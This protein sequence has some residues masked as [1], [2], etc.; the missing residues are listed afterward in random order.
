MM[1]YIPIAILSVSIFLFGCE[2]LKKH[3]FGSSDNKITLKADSLNVVTMKN[4]MVIHEGVCRGCAYEQS[5]HFEIADTAGI[6]ALDHVVT[7]DNN[8]KDMDGGNVSKDLVLV[9]KKTGTATI[10]MYKFS[11]EIP[12]AKDSL[13][14]SDF[15][16]EVKN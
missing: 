16:I 14:F 12:D 15:K 7:T 5:T 13:N 11:K 6:V 9:P 1:R 8:P 2:H 3:L 4:K 10:R